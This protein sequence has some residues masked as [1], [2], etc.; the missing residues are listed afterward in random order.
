MKWNLTLLLSIAYL[1][2]HNTPAIHRWCI[3]VFA[4]LGQSRRVQAIR[5]E[6]SEFGKRGSD[7]AGSAC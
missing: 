5:S 1:S 4:R 6:E 7:E 2:T 3:D